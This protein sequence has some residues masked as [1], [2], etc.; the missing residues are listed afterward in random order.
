MN[1]FRSRLSRIK[2]HLEQLHDGPDVYGF[3]GVSKDLLVKEIDSLYGLSQFISEH[4]AEPFAFEVIALKRASSRFYQQ[5]KELFDA[6]DGAP[7]QESFDEFLNGL[8]TLVEKTK[9]VCSLMSNDGFMPA[10]VVGNLKEEAKQF[11]TCFDLYSKELE[12]AKEAANEFA[13]AKASIEDSLKTIT[14]LTDECE[15]L[16]TDA[17]KHAG[18]IGSAHDEVLSWKVEIEKTNEASSRANEAISENRTSIES[19]KAQIDETAIRANTLL[20]E[21]ESESEQSKLLLDEAKETLGN[22]NRVSMAA[23]F[24]ERKEQLM[25]SLFIWG[26]LFVATVLGLAYCAN[27]L[28]ANATGSFN[29]SQF[30]LRIAVMSPLVWLGWYSARQYGF[31]LRLKED[32]AYKYAVSVAYEG[33]KK[34]VG[35]TD[36]NLKELLLELSMFNMANSPM[37]VF[38]QKKHGVKGLPLEE[39]IEALQDKFK[40]LTKITV[41][42]RT[43]SVTAEM[44]GIAKENAN[45]ED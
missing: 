45:D 3:P 39:A 10:A 36:A 2:K 25:P 20:K 37:R 13:S 43:G 41:N 4:E 5:Y 31:A 34:A 23:S 42:P 27:H 8:T 22:T 26:G 30:L 21:I 18:D 15:T 11:K 1:T 24:K 16:R 32:Y 14:D 17:K 38:T 40:R 6:E 9:V 35:E 33:F 28:F 7:R 44:A 29:W 12:S 19:Q